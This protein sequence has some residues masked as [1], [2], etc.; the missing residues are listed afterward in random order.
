MVTVAP[1][2]NCQPAG[3]CSTIWSVPGRKA[4]VARSAIV[5]GFNVVQAG[6]VPPVAAEL[7]QMDVL[8]A[9]VTDTCEKPW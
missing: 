1:V 7:L 2:Q 6:A 9:G 5:M 4:F 8:F 3:A